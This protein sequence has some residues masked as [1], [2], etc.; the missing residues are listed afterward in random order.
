MAISWPEYADSD[1][2][3][4]RYLEK[5]L[6][7]QIQKSQITLIG[8]L[9]L[10]APTNYGGTGW[11][12]AQIAEYLIEKPV[13]GS[14][15]AKSTNEVLDYS[16][17][18]ATWAVSR[19][20]NLDEGTILWKNSVLPDNKLTKV[21]EKF[22]LAIDHL[23]LET[24]EGRLEGRQRHITLA[25]LHALIPIYATSKFV[26]AMS[27]GH[28]YHRSIESIFQNVLENE[29][30]PVAVRLLFE[31]EKE[32]AFDLVE[33][34]LSVLSTGKN[35]GLP[36]RL[37][38]ALLSKR[39]ATAT[40]RIIF[41][42]RPRAIFSESESE[43]FV[44]T[45]QGWRVVNEND[46]AES[47][48]SLCTGITF[49]LNSAGAS[50]R[51]L[52]TSR[53]FLIFGFDG[54]LI[55]S[56]NIPSEGGILVFESGVGLQEESLATERVDMAKWP[57]WFWAILAPDTNLQLIDKFGKEHFIRSKR[58]IQL[59]EFI[60]PQLITS[61][62]VQVS[63]SWPQLKEDQIL[64][65][66]DNYS[67]DEIDVLSTKGTIKRGSGGI[68]DISIF[69][70]IG[71]S[72]NLNL[73]VMPGLKVEGLEEP[74]LKGE[75]RKITFRLPEGWNGPESVTVDSAKLD[76]SDFVLIAEPNGTR[77]KIFL[78]LPLLNWTIE[79]DG[80][81][82]TKMLTEGK[83]PFEEIKRVKALVIHDTNMKSLPNL[84][85][86]EVTKNSVSARVPIEY[87]GHYRFD[88][89]T[90]RDSNESKR[91]K[92]EIGIFG[93]Q[94]SLCDFRT[95]QNIVV[96]DLR[97]LPAA[98]IAAEIFTESDWLEYRNQKIAEAAIIRLRNRRFTRGGR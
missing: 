19:A 70:G 33:R 8:E 87:R 76:D 91:V 60:I 42:E 90:L 75:K 88:L 98:S 80:Q 3:N 27:I 13:I 23:G 43:I 66:I 63:N 7:D 44:D 14:N 39:S 54:R 4:P 34:S 40:N 89:R 1:S 82:P 28:R 17:T 64:R 10:T 92:I 2:K 86:Y 9:D 48:G 45:P 93:R 74:M 83:F 95:K 78:K 24:F 53:G 47:A 85:I 59:E 11:S 79:F 55:D 12:M 52:D 96:K 50:F 6:R 58:G 67:G 20:Q 62:G 49:A 30:M 46:K 15:L 32:I 26:E 22:S 81:E 61:Q 71:K 5:F 35:S 36:Q 97:D 94:I 18:I 38:H 21:A 68:I 37:A 84:K 65:V 41:R 72:R 57:N 77:H 73:L 25:R 51:L 16:A 31:T 56:L 29:V 69:G